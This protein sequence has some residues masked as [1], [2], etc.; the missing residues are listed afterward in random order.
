[1]GAGTCL[2]EVEVGIERMVLCLGVFNISSFFENGE[3]ESSR[4]QHTHLPSA[5]NALAISSANN[6]GYGH[7]VLAR[8]EEG[9]HS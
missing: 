9:E 2:K 6:A 7:W 4:R 1:V 5:P 3:G 8:E